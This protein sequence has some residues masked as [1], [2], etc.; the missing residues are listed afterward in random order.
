MVL[1][2]AVNVRFDEVSMSVVH[3]LSLIKICREDFG[4]NLAIMELVWFV[5]FSLE[6]CFTR[7]FV[8]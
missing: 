3:K 6:S 1:K 5:S 7:T 4:V 2:S 8:F